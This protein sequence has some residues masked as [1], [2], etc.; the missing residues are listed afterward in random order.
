MTTIKKNLYES[1]C[2]GPFFLVC[3][4]SLA[5]KGTYRGGT[6][7][8]CEDSGFHVVENFS[9]FPNRVEVDL[10]GSML[11]DKK[12]GGDFYDF[13]LIDKDTLAVLIANVSGKGVPVA[14]FMVI[15]KTLIKNNAQYGLGTK[16]VFDKVND[17]LCADN[18]A[19]MFV[20]AFMGYM[21]I[22]TGKS[23]GV[24][25]GHNLPLVK[26]G[27]VFDWL[28]VKRGLVLAAMR[29]KEE[30]TK[31]EPGDILYL[32]TDGVTEA[33]TSRQELFSEARLLEVAI[34]HEETQDLREF[35]VSIR[36]K[37]DAFTRETEQADDITMLAL[38][39]KGG[40]K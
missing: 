35:T 25:A 29:Y 31:F 8:C 40:T 12:A 15:A 18:E 26:R 22:P 11:P 17:L 37:F 19:G 28:R 24:N 16:E 39:Y 2:G 9:P 3:I 21:G 1:R 5:I 4:V 23:T 34:V 30:E 27:G 6:Q 14:L 36:Q 33:V 13:F 7:H 10:Y 20:T 32:Y 38:R